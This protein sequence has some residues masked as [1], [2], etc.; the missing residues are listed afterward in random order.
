MSST[1]NSWN[2]KRILLLLLIVLVL[3]TITA[4]AAEA[5]AMDRI[6]NTWSKASKYVKSGAYWVNALI[7]FIIG[8]LLF[9]FLL[10]DK[11]GSDNTQKAIMY[12]LLVVIALLIAS[13]ILAGGVP[14]YMWKTEQLDRFTRFLIGPRA[15]VSTGDCS[16]TG[17]YFTQVREETVCR[18]AILRTNQS[19]AGLPA[20]IVA[21]LLLYLMFN[22]Y[23]ERFGFDKM[24][25][26]G[27]KWFPIIL[28]MMFAGLIANNGTTKNMLLVTGGWIAV[29][30]I[31]AAM[32]KTM[33]DEK[34]QSGM[35]KGLA[36]GIAFAFVQL[37][38]NM[39]GT[40]LFGA[41][42]AA[43]DIDMTIIFR[44]LL[45]GI[46]VGV[47]YSFM[48]RKGVGRNWRD[49]V[50][51]KQE[52]EIRQLE[53]QGSYG[54]AWLKQAGFLEKLPWIGK[55]IKKW[56]TP[57]ELDKKISAERKIDESIARLWNIYNE[58]LRRKPQRPG[59]LKRILGE[60]EVLERMRNELL[61]SEVAKLRE[62][63]KKETGVAAPAE[64]PKHEERPV[65]PPTDV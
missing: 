54:K 42:Y 25:A 6:K 64:A 28:S 59:E 21:F 50:N 16:G 62:E 30:L 31:G 32:S 45:I 56:L 2:A 35:K 22:V 63:A 18:Q 9:T 55:R 27:G 43:A 44:N 20:F 47:I 23:G 1:E 4:D 60:I 39:L 40:S 48:A 65:T 46:I 14:Q 61:L 11:I 12:I 49:H 58:E 53:E 41:E 17:A 38:L 33:S 7:I 57:K 51:R 5:A 36:F 8:F 19:G 37:I 29:V 24:G 10:K 3:F 52:E 26:G 15:A 34:D 13:K